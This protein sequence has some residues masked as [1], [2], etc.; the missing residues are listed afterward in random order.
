MFGSI[1]SYDW[2]DYFILRPVVIILK[3]TMLR[4]KENCNP[5][6]RHL[7]DNNIIKSFCS[8]E[9]QQQRQPLCKRHAQ[10]IGQFFCHECQSYNICMGCLQE[11]QGHSVMQFK[12]S[13]EAKEATRETL[14]LEVEQSL[15]RLKGREN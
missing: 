6:Q 2:V 1:T 12:D 14:L 7:A 9:T 3:L 13:E 5:N 10:R 4:Q 8:Q 11:H 15:N